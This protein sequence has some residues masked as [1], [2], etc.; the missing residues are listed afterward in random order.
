MNIKFKKMYLWFKA[1]PKFFG[2]LVAA[3]APTKSPP[4]LVVPDLARER[5][6]G[7]GLGPRALAPPSLTLELVSE[8][9]M[10]A[11]TL[12]LLRLL[13]AVLPLH[14]LLLTLTPDGCARGFWREASRDCEDARAMWLQSGEW[15][16]VARSLVCRTMG[17]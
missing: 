8:R 10:E 6:P 2:L 16:P 4:L 15:P 17:E 9:F 5:P 14:A 1:P 11:E 13:L 12:L 7:R 3:P